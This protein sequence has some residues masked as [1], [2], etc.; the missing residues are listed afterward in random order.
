MKIDAD[1]YKRILELKNTIKR[2]RLIF[3]DNFSI[4]FT[5]LNNNYKKNEE[6]FMNNIQTHNFSIAIVL[7]KEITDMH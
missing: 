3:P 2:E 5:Y 1:I 6:S 7:P 4:H